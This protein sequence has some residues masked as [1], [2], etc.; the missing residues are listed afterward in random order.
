ME[1]DESLAESALF[2]SVQDALDAASLPPEFARLLTVTPV[3]YW[4]VNSV[5]SVGDPHTIE[6]AISCVIKVSGKELKVAFWRE[7]LL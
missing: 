6:S 1:E 7:G 2:E 3:A 5:G 4:T